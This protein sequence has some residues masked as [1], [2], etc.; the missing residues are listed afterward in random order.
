MHTISDGWGEGWTLRVRDGRP[1]YRSDDGA[2]QRAPMRLLARHHSV[3]S[4]LWTWLRQHGVRR[5]SPSGTSGPTTPEA[6]RGTVQVLV[7]LAPDV[8]ARLRELAAERGSTVSAIVAGWVTA[9]K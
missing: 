1:E 4:D 5:P 6:Q 2:W 9:T 7:R 3:D 8:A